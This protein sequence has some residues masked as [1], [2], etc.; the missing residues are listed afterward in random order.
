MKNTSMLIT[1]I[2]AVAS[3]TI[4][5]AASTPVLHSNSETS[6]IHNEH[7]VIEPKNKIWSEIKEVQKEQIKIRQ[8]N[9]SKL[10]SKNSNAPTTTSISKSIASTVPK[11]LDPHKSIGSPNR[12]PN[13]PLPS[14]GVVRQDTKG[15]IMKA[16]AYSISKKQTGKTDGITYTETKATEGR[17]VAVDPKVIPLGSVLSIEYKDENGR[18][19]KGQFVAEDIGGAIKGNKIDIYFDTENE[20]KRFGRKDVTVTILK[21]GNW[22][23]G[24]RQ[25]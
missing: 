11:K 12:I 10:I 22:K 8:A 2:F 15:M 17:T 25:S 14:R 16:T 18:L 7:I 20:S 9:K 1:K 5:A 21:K 4:T 23:R 6:S 24:A 3:I 19:K 13:N